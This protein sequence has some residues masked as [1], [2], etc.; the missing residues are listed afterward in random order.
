MT[1]REIK[2]PKYVYGIRFL[3]SDANEYLPVVID[4]L[5]IMGVIWLFRFRSISNIFMVPDPG[6]KP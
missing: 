2:N 4:K 1:K 3:N 6:L 5:V